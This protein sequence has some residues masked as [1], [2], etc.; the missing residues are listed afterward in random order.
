MALPGLCPFGPPTRPLPPTASSFPVP[1]PPE[2]PHPSGKKLSIIRSPRGFT[3]SAPICCRSTRL[4][5]KFEVVRTE[6]EA[7]AQGGTR[8]ARRR[9]GGAGGG[10]GDAGCRGPGRPLTTGSPS[11]FGPEPGSG[12]RDG[13]DWPARLRREGGR[14]TTGVGSRGAGVPGVHRART[15]EVAGGWRGLTPQR[16]PPGDQG[17]K[18]NPLRAGWRTPGCPPRLRTRSPSHLDARG[19]PGSPPPA[20]R[21]WGRLGPGDPPPR[22]SRGPRGRPRRRSQ[23]VSRRMSSASGIRAAREPPEPMSALRSDPRSERPARARPPGGPGA[24]ATGLAPASHPDPGEWEAAPRA[25]GLEAARTTGRFI[26][27]PRPLPRA[28][29]PG[30]VRPRGQGKGMG[31]DWNGTPLRTSGPWTPWSLLFCWVH[32]IEPILTDQGIDPQTHTPGPPGS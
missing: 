16:S 15:R 4:E 5:R 3:A 19:P 2:R 29:P 11:C 28:C 12:G 30:V 13:P 23:P 7:E 1:P 26:P 20:P 32:V 18:A 8:S 17:T 10:A 14:L 31:G 21:S 24:K 27:G 22:P 6:R 9:G 25:A